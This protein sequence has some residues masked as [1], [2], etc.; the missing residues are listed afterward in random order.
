MNLSDAIA[1]VFAAGI[2]TVLLSFVFPLAY[3]ALMF[4]ALASLLKRPRDQDRT[5]WVLIIIFVPF[6]S[7][8]YF[9]MAKSGPTKTLPSS[10]PPQISPLKPQLPVTP[11]SAPPIDHSRIYDERRR[12]EAIN[13]ALSAMGRSNRKS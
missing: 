6:G 4:V 5:T 12:A 13:Q 2:L 8:F 1:G 7:I 10:I 9:L 11:S 3:F